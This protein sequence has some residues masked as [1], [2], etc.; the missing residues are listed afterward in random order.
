MFLA[1]RD[2][3]AKMLEPWLVGRIE[4]VGST[5][6]PGLAAKPVIDIMAPVKD[7]ESSRAALRALEAV[8]Y[9]YAPYKS[10]SMHWLCKPGPELRTHHLHLVPLNTRPWID[11]LAFRDLLISDA[12]VARDYA[13]LKHRL[14]AAHR[15]DRERYTEEK[16]P[17]IESAL[18]GVRTL[19][20]RPIE[21][22]DIEPV[23]RLLSE[24]AT[25]FI[26]AEFGAPAQGRFLAE[27]N[28]DALRGFLA[29]RFRYH[30]AELNHE[31]VGFV[32]VRENKHLYHLFVAKP[33]QRRGIGRALWEFAKEDCEALGHRG[34]FTVNSSNHAVPVYERWGFR[35][36][37]EP[38]T[39]NGITYNP[40]K[41]EGAE[42]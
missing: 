33:L 12:S 21:P 8:G 15:N 17:F 22:A 36:D 5:A 31:L 3:L 42:G 19:T 18:R 32:G 24:L 29:N 2:L 13:A 20:I 23:A 26:V 39:S 7:L 1:E 6:V 10:E 25:E 4:H 38:R 34:A 11:S 41:L 14:A 35:R 9:C 30:V 16:G 28:A 40:M 27:N 37:G